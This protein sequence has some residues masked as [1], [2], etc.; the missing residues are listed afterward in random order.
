VHLHEPLGETEGL[1]ETVGF[2]KTTESMWWRTSTNASRGEFHTD[3]GCIAETNVTPHVVKT[4]QSDLT[5]LEWVKQRAWPT[6]MLLK[7]S[8]EAGEASSVSGQHQ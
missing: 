8:R 4:Y 7:G 3:V 1:I 6:P 2:K 5:T